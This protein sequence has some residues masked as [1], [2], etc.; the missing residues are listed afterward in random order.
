MGMTGGNG[1][2]GARVKIVDHGDNADRYNIVI[3]GDGYRASQLSKYRKD[4][5]AVVERLHNTAPFTELWPGINVHRIDVSSTEEGAA[6]PLACVGG[7]GANPKTFFGASFCNNGIR[8]L[9]LVDT[10]SALSVARSK[11]PE[12]HFILCLVNSPI[13][14]GAGGEVATASL[15]PG[16]IDIAIHEMGHSAFGLADEYE[17]FRG[18]TSG[19]A[20]HNVHPVDEPAEPNVTTNGDGPA[21]KWAAHLTAPTEPR[22]TTANANCAQCDPQAN[23]RPSGF[24]GAFEGAH[25]FHCGAFRPAFDCKM[26][27]LSADFCAV[28]Q[29]VIRDTLDPFLPAAQGS[30]TGP[31]IILPVNPPPIG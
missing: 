14:G 13:H 19:E 29:Q 20:G 26:R 5:R 6:D 10:Q 25:Y 1:H 11:V 2:V 16:A 15:A 3:L 23:P 22:P 27:K 28:C 18:C 9:L 31:Q 8:R 17:Y 24:V 7:T 12:A 4:V 30:P 21:I